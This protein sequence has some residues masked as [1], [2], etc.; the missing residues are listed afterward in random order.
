MKGFSIF[1]VFWFVLVIAFIFPE[2]NNRILDMAFT[3]GPSQIVNI[4]PWIFLVFALIVPLALVFRG[5]Q[6]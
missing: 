2:M 6:F 1:Y 3:T 4:I 5:K